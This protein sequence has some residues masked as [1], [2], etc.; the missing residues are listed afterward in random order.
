[1]IAAIPLEVLDI[2]DPAIWLSACLTVFLTVFTGTILFDVRD[3]QGD[4]FH[5]KETLPILLGSDRTLGWT[6]L[7]HVVV[8][9][10]L[11]G[12]G[13]LLQE[14]G[15]LFNAVL[16]PGYGWLLLNAIRRHKRITVSLWFEVLV[17]GMAMVP[18]VAALAPILFN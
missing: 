5:G 9:L 7:L 3:L 8:L 11:L 18:L 12:S 1:V 17:D 10:V 6:T 14:P 4:R 16:T 13:L 2:S 15:S